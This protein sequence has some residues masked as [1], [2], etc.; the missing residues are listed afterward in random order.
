MGP[1][2]H[3]FIVPTNIPRSRILRVVNLWAIPPH[4]PRE[5]LNR[6]NKFL[7]IHFG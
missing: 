7:T 3:F 4:K 1:T 6:H 5:V 2:L